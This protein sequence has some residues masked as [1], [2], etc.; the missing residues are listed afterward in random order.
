MLRL[1]IIIDMATIYYDLEHKGLGEG[2]EV[3]GFNIEYGLYPI[4]V[5]KGDTVVFNFLGSAYTFS[6]QWSVKG[7]DSDNYSNITSAVVDGPPNS[8]TGTATFTV[9]TGNIPT[10]G[11]EDILSIRYE[12]SGGDAINDGEDNLA[13]RFYFFDPTGEIPDVDVTTQYLAVPNIDTGEDPDLLDNETTNF[14]IQIYAS[15]QNYE[16]TRNTIYE[17]REEGYLGPVLED[18]RGAGNINLI[19]HLPAEGEV[20]YY[21]LTARRIEADST[22]IIPLENKVLKRQFGDTAF[23][24]EVRNSQ[25]EVMI[26]MTKRLPKLAVSSTITTIGRTTT[27]QTHN[28]LVPGFEFGDDWHVLVAVTSAYWE[29]LRLDEYRLEYNDGLT[30]NGSEYFNIVYLQRATDEANTIAYWVYKK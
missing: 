27:E 28:I 23:G 10:N 24:F 13:I 5:F 17:I 22:L 15:A 8:E 9:N 2:W 30:I 18:R 26:D 16:K 25:D 4:N 6:R 19:D 20:K 1:S 11:S 12:D 3:D 21:Y 14:S 29:P 7:I